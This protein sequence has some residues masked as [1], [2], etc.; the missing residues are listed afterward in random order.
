[1]IIR[2]DQLKLAP[3]T[4]KVLNTEPS[5]YVF[6]EEDNEAELFANLLF[7][8]MIELGGVGLSA[9]QVGVD[10]KV[11][12]M[13]VDD[14]RINVFN[15]TIL[16]YS[17]EET[18]FNEGCLSFP[19]ITIDVKRPAWVEVQ[20][21]NIKGGTIIERFDGLTGR[22]FQHEYDHMM[23]KTFKDQV[24][25]M[26]WAMAIKKFKNKKEKIVKKYSS[27]ILLDVY[28]ELKDGNANTDRV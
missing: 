11:F 7:N 20:Y 2:K 3:T 6:N 12:V 16:E 19:G 27:K 10:A 8:R 18:S 24:S 13:G 17:K 23:G 21:Q 4:S 22:I 15:P 14:I 5:L 1:M 9:N 28:K 26:K 25:P